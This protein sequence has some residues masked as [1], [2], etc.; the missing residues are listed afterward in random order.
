[1]VKMIDEKAARDLAV[2]LFDQGKRP[3]DLESKALW[4]KPKTTYNY[5]QE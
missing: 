1:M 3:S 5:F 4:L 2:E